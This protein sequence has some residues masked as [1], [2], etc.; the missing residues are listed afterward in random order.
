MTLHEQALI[1]ADE[2]LEIW[3]TIRKEDNLHDRKYIAKNINA[4]HATYFKLKR[5]INRN[6]STEEKKRR[7][8]QQKIDSEFVITKKQLSSSGTFETPLLEPSF[9]DNDQMQECASENEDSDYEPPQRKPKKIRR[10]LT[11]K[12]VASLDHAGLSN[13]KAASVV[14][15]TAHYL[16]IDARDV[17][18]SR[19]SIQRNRS[20]IRSQIANDIKN[21]FQENLTE[22]FFVLHWDGKILPKWHGVDGKNDKL[23]MVISSG[24]ITKILGV[25][26]LKRGTALEQFLA[27]EKLIKEWN[28]EHVIKGICFDTTSVNTGERS[29]TCKLLRDKFKGKVL[30]L[31]CR[32]HV[33]EILLSGVYSTAMKDKSQS[34]DISLFVRFKSQWNKLDLTKIESG[35]SYEGIQS[36]LGEANL[37]QL[38]S[39]IKYQLSIQKTTRKDYIEFLELALIF[40]NE[41]TY[42]GKQIHIRLPG[43]L[44]RARFMARAI[45]SLKIFAFRSQFNL[46][47]KC[48]RVKIKKHKIS[49]TTLFTFR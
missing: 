8:F 3:R 32:H 35:V 29:G 16:D 24:E 46:T 49:F 48:V 23:A 27:I 47:G 11:Q 2:V 17:P 12:L 36:C 15:T 43:A 10:K 26:D 44:H 1:I 21:V 4:L 28:V 37:A 14:L 20:S 38:K 41:K 30:T 13:A 31:A 39:H 22:S 7:Q 25:A 42:N 5:S 18:L 33:L 6:T 45:Y 40:L 9:E 19:S 34:P